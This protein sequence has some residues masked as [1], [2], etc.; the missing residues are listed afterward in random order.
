MG[1]RPLPAEASKPPPLAD[2]KVQGTARNATGH[3]DGGFLGD[4]A[5]RASQFG[6]VR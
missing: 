4:A 2:A 3:I 1:E 6:V 5:V